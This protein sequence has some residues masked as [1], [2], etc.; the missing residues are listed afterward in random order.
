MS[1]DLYK[2][3]NE[4]PGKA[5]EIT[6]Q[7]I[8]QSSEEEHSE[9]KLEAQ[10]I[11]NTAL[12]RIGEYHEARKEFPLLIKQSKDRK[13]TD[14]E[15]QA[16]EEYAGLMLLLNDKKETLDS[17][18]RCFLLAVEEGRS[19]F[20]IKSLCGIGK[21]FWNDSDYESARKYHLQAVDLA[22][23]YP[24]DDM[25]TYAN[26]SL[27]VDYISM[28]EFD[29]C[30][31]M[32]N[33]H[34]KI[35]L[36]QPNEYWHS[37]FYFYLGKSQI[38]GDLIDK[39]EENLQ[40]AK[41][42]VDRLSFRWLA[43]PILQ[44][45]HFL[46][47]MKN[48]K[49]EAAGAIEKAIE[50]AGLSGSDRYLEEVHLQ[51]SEF[52]E[53]EK[54]FEKALACLE[55][56]SE[57]GVSLLMNRPSESSKKITKSI[58]K[59]LKKVS[60]ARLQIINASMNSDLKES[61]NRIRDLE[62]KSFYDA[63]TK[64]HNRRALEEKFNVIESLKPEGLSIIIIDLD[65]FKSIN[66]TFGHAAGDVVLSRV[67][68]ILLSSCRKETEFVARYGGE[69][70][71]ILF[72]SDSVAAAIGLAKRIQQ[73]LRNFDWTSILP[74]RNLTA[75]LGVAF[76]TTNQGRQLLEVA[77]LALYKAKEEGRNRIR[78]A[79]GPNFSIEPA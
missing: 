1:S 7:I 75:S 35:M 45:Y 30:R 57:Y 47:V 11:R 13:L 62:H 24:Q 58:K 28:G 52:Y 48:R 38:H 71:C 69:E 16:L 26:L 18:I 4:D 2:I 73:N 41:E 68:E 79:E 6:Q 15:L 22:N 10:L 65:Y 33:R 34:K 49:E 40:A 12:I 14:L 32:L 74:D 31:E 64:A 51:A 77:D 60:E 29:L 76:D 53:N 67:G 55:K 63:L 39:G 72:N 54:D 59:A 66:D 37:E 19:D 42:L 44:E 61:H 78:F 70:F 46:Y 21:A 23:L 25:I 27:A 36:S 9:A 3:L 5:I 20:A 8:D 50:A 56:A 43:V 17:W